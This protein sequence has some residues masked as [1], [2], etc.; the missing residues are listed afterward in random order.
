MKVSVSTTMDS[1]PGITSTARQE[2]EGTS[3]KPELE[4]KDELVQVLYPCVK[5]EFE[6]S[7]QPS[8]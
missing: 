1:Q 2:A 4:Y 7:S 5:F 6:N 8:I 3:N